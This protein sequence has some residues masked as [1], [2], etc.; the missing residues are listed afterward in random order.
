[1]ATVMLT[2]DMVTPTFN[3]KDVKTVLTF[4]SVDKIQWCD[5]SNTT[6]YAL[7][8]HGIVCF[9]VCND[10][11]FG[12]YFIILNYQQQQKQFYYLL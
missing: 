1:M 3:F 11:K 4:E 9:S 10:I 5:H 6:F 12:A 8:S 2:G 7:L